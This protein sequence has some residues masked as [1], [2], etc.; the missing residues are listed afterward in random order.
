MHC[1]VQY[2]YIFIWLVSFGVC[3]CF[4]DLLCNIHT[5][6]H[7]AKHGMFVIK[8]WLGGEDMLK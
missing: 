8:P 1:Y 4:R 2:L 3:L 5:F 6:S 7:T